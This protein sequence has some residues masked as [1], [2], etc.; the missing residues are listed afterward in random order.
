MDIRPGDIVEGEV[1]NLTDFGA[2]VH[3]GGVD[4]LVHTSDLAWQRIPHPSAV[5]N[6]GDIVKVKVLEVDPENLRLSLSLKHLQPHPWEGVAEKYPIGSK[7]TGLV[8]K[9]IDYGAFVELEP[10]VEGLVHLSEMAWGRRPNHPSELLSEG[11]QV[12]IVILNVDIEKQRIS[13]GMKQAKPDPWSLVT[14]KYPVGSVI[15]GQVTEFANYGAYIKVEDGIEG[16]LHVADLSWTQRFSHPQDALKKGQKLRLRV[17]S[18]DRRN[19]NLELSLKQTRPNPWDEIIKQIPPGS[20]LKASIKEVE[21]RGV[22]VEVDKGLDGFVPGSHLQKRGEPKNNYSAGEEINL[23]V[24]RVEP[25]RKRILLS[26]REFYRAEE[27]EEVMRYKP[28]PARMNIGEVLK[29]ELEKMEELKAGVAEEI[30]TEE[31]PTPEE[32]TTE[33]SETMAVAAE[34]EDAE[35]KAES[36]PEAS[37]AEEEPA[38]ETSE[39]TSEETPEET[40]DETP[41][42][43]SEEMPEETAEETSKETS[44]ETSEEPSEETPEETTGDSPE[45]TPEEPAEEKGDESE[46]PAEDKGKAK[47]KTTKKST[48]KSTKKKKE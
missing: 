31:E 26:E 14:E 38:E 25:E 41:E 28:E 39:E 34:H 19:R 47:K 45:E 10:K 48:K 37:E 43:T 21:D 4:G 27:R 24:L 3:V 46:E 42:E 18:I 11:S 35:P 16:F 30:E 40:S 13:L 7:H 8:K 1:K 15:K 5:V 44:E 32:P 22:V 6:P 12:E 33:E 2:F 29:A 17:Q 23:Q 20:T 9:I 36:E